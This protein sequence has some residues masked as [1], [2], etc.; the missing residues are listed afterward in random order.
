MRQLVSRFTSALGGTGV[1]VSLGS[2]TGVSVAVTVA[3]SVGTITVGVAGSAMVAVAFAAGGTVGDVTAS[4]VALLP[5]I[6]QA[7]KT[8]A[9]MINKQ[10]SGKKI[11]RMSPL[12]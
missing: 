10:K 3:V 7:D 8:N 12:E 9:P 11:L 6:L 2:G 5:G 1:A 4:A